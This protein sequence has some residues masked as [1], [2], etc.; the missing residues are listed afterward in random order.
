MIRR[1]NQALQSQQ[2]AQ[3]QQQQQPQAQ[4]QAQQNNG[5]RHVHTNLHHKHQQSL[6]AAAQPIQVPLQRIPLVQQQ[7]PVRSVF[8]PQAQQLHRQNQVVH[9]Q[10]ALQPAANANPFAPNPFTPNP[11]ALR[12]EPNLIVAG[13]AWQPPAQQTPNPF[14]AL[15][16]PQ[17]PLAAALPP[18]IV[19]Q[20]PAN[21]FAA[22]WLQP[23]QPSA[24]A[25]LAN[26]FAGWLQPQPQPPAPAQ[27]P[28]P[29][30]WLQPQQ[31]P[32]AQQQQFQWLP[33]QQQADPLAQTRE[34]LQAARSFGVNI[35]NPV[36]PVAAAAINN[37]ATLAA[38]AVA[39]RRAQWQQPL[40]QPS[41]QPHHQPQPQPPRGW[42]CAQ[43]TFDNHTAL[44]SCE[45]CSCPKGRAPPADSGANES[46][47]AM[48]QQALRMSEAPRLSIFT[49][50]IADDRQDFP[51]AAGEYGHYDKSLAYE[52][53]IFGGDADDSHQ[54]ARRSS[55]L[56][57]APPSSYASPAQ[58]PR[59][60]HASGFERTPSPPAHSAARLV[61]AVVFD[62]HDVDHSHALARQ[63]AVG[64]A[65]RG[66]SL[67][68]EP[69]LVPVLE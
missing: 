34:R 30:A 1:P 7:E 15:L 16:R 57:Y 35:V 31:Q 64:R 39:A 45:V 37:P 25:Q 8:P 26:P 28:P 53:S 67:K 21:Q 12:H 47:S 60:R 3:W 55:F 23:Q 46:L 40:Q 58:A 38:S 44:T 36:A 32:P 13:S 18:P 2:Q 49:S 61:D 5:R 4:W 42:A 69:L 66:R 52:S 43:C 10:P 50:A 27:Q 17:P 11:F 41:P 24:P 9:Q 29:F 65:G 54:R 62:Q 19:A 20:Q 6:P 63:A 22:G 59:R 51:A 56:S 48:E 14:A 33:Q 68:L